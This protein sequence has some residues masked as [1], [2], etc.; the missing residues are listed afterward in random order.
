M[1]VVGGKLEDKDV[2]A[3]VTVMSTESSAECRRQYR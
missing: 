2:G 1:P 3:R